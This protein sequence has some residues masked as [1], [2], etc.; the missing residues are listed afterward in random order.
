MLRVM[1][2][3]HD[4]LA[5]RMMSDALQHA[6]RVSAVH[7]AG[8]AR[9]ALELVRYYRPAV[10]ILDMAVPPNGAL[11]VIGKVLQLAPET[12]IVTVSV[13]E[14]EMAVAAL[15]A[16]AAGH[17]HKDVDPDEFASLVVRAAEGEA[18]VPQRVLAPLLELVR[19]VPDNGWRPLH[20]RL[21]T[22]EWEIIE[23]LGEGSTTQVIAD[24]LTVSSTTVYS[25][26]KSILRKLGVNTRRDAVVAAE[27]LRRE[28]VSGMPR[29]QPMRPS[30]A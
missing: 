22:R 8:D 23:L 29:S 6:D 24:R 7:T 14:P 21:T 28:E 25:H 26:V 15:R 20:S 19:T 27:R 11:D 12:R 13:D 10:T 18:I 3:D 5:R 17:I 2:A 4:G 30:Y 16:G 1:I 9:E